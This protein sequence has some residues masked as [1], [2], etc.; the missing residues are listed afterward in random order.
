MMYILNNKKKERE[1]DATEQR[2]AN[3]CIYVYMCGKEGK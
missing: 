1:Q 2:N 3:T